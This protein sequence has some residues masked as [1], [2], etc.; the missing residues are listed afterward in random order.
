ME[1]LLQ[2]LLPVMQFSLI[3]LLEVCKFFCRNAACA[4][5]IF[6][7]HLPHVVAP[8]ARRT[9]RQASALQSMGLA[10]GGSAAA[11]LSHRLGQHDHRDT[12]LR[13]L[14]RLP[15][16]ERTTPKI[17][18]MDDCAFRKGVIEAKL[19]RG[20]SRRRQRQISPIFD[21]IHNFGLY[22]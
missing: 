17:L 18:G 10:L 19:Q 13:L 7:E 6:T 5:R 3:I 16:P 20:A 8:W 11:R 22:N 2:Q 1:E 21:I 14:S 15:L 12:I 9:V 4:R